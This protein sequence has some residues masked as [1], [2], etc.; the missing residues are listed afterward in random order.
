MF[1]TVASRTTLAARAEHVRAFNRFYT[2]KIGLLGNGLL[3]S[4]Y[5][6]TEVRLLYELAQQDGLTPTWLSQ[7]LGLN[8]GYVSRVLRG[9]KQ[10]GWLRERASESDG[11]QTLLSLSAAGRK[12]FVPLNQAS[13]DEAAALLN[14]L[15]PA[16]QQQLLAAMHTISEVLG[17]SSAAS[18]PYLIRTHRPGDLGWM[19]M[20]HGALYAQEFGWSEEFEGFVAEIAAHFLKH[21]DPA[22]ERFWIAEQHGENVGCVALVKQS[23]TVAKLRVLLVEPSA[24][25][26]GIG[27]RLTQECEHFA[28][29]AGYKKIML[30]T[31]RNLAA[32]RAIYQ[33]AGYQL[34]AEEAHHSFGKDLTGETWELVL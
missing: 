10:R 28:R 21:Y 8:L 7:Q 18:E 32:A 16:K 30:W 23:K 11:R 6:L 13:H 15:P 22:C 5:S 29:Q 33:K 2:R 27:K 20:R 4:P 26:L 17:E 9:F 14:T 31:N 25:G 34:I 19:V 24:R 1:P 12:A 3:D